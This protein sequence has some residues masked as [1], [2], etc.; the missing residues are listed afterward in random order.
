MNRKNIMLVGFCGLMILSALFSAISRRR[1]EVEPSHQLVDIPDSRFVPRQRPIEGTNIAR[2]YSNAIADAVEKVMPSVVVIRTE[3]VS[4]KRQEMVDLFGFRKYYRYVPEELM[5]EGSGVII[6]ERGHVLTSWHVIEGARDGAVVLNDGTKMA[7]ELIGFDRATDLAVL[8]IKGEGINCPAVE[9]GD[10]DLVR[11]GEVVIAIGSPFSLQSSVTVGHVSQKGRKVH[12][13]P[14]EDFI[15]T[16]AA[17]NEGNS[18]GPLIDVDGRL[19]GI[20]TAKKTDDQQKGVG[21]AFAVPSDLA[22]V[23]A[24]SIIEKGVHEWPWIG[25]TFY[26]VEKNY[27]DGIFNGAG[28]MISQV[29]N[30]T[31][32]SRAGLQSGTAVLQVDG[33]PVQTEQDIERIIYNK[34]VGDSVKFLF[35]LKEKEQLEVE[36]LLEEFPG[37]TG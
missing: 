28:V 18:G 4:V 11:V 23:V 22:M 19:I 20:N 1:A 32:A 31:P 16:D 5:G 26:T 15:Q 10:S 13:L 6:D 25:A 14:Y 8:K 9:F 30:N 37:M 33:I 29:W 24:K 36:L 3:K 35:E 2:E 17:I 12:I 34:S 7:A 27:R 21:I